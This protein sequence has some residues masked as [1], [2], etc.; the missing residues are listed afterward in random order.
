[1]EYIL[2]NKQPTS[3]A[4]DLFLTFF[5]CHSKKNLESG[6]IGLRQQTQEQKIPGNKKE[7]PCLVIVFLIPISVV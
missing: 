3:P 6:L 1:M 2:P 7:H 4:S 5:L